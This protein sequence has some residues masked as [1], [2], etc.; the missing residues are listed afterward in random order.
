[1][2]F[3]ES[4]KQA[5]IAT[6]MLMYKEYRDALIREGLDGE[7]FEKR[8]VDLPEVYR[9]AWLAVGASSLKITKSTTR[10]LLNLAGRVF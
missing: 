1:M 8:W 7:D 5:I 6:A 3:T 4:D 9:V 2:A 10:V